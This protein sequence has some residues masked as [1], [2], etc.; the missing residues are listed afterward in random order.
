MTKDDVISLAKDLTGH[1]A[2]DRIGFDNLF[3]FRLQKFVQRKKYWWRQRVFSF[4]TIPGQPDYDLN[5]ATDM[6]SAGNL[7]PDVQQIFSIFGMNGST[8]FDVN[9]TFDP[10]DKAEL[11]ASEADGDDQPDTFFWKPGTKRTLYLSP[12]PAGVYTMWVTYW[13]VAP[14]DKD[15]QSTDGS[16]VMDFVPDYLHHCVVAGMVMDIK[17]FLYGGKDGEY[18]AALQNYNESLESADQDRDY[19]TDR[20]DEFRTSE[21]GVNASTS[22]I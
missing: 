10:K 14:S 20:V 12:T 9:A 16:D 15:Y 8:K 13:A 6:G 19:S 7:H 18:L 1:K 11:M 3:V 5:D 22:R 2:D 17:S 4:S 21:A